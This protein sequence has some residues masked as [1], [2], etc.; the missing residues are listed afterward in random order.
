MATMYSRTSLP[1]EQDYIWDG[2]ESVSD[3]EDMSDCRYSIDTEEAAPNY[4]NTKIDLLY[5]EYKGQLG[6]R[7]GIESTDRRSATWDVRGHFWAV[8]NTLLTFK[9]YIKADG[10]LEAATSHVSPSLIIHTFRSS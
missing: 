2:P 6:R 8:E 7:V 3:D 4:T 10:T 1:D 9:G 5:Y